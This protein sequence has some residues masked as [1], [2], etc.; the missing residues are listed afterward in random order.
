MEFWKQKRKSISKISF[1]FVFLFLITTPFFSKSGNKGLVK[2]SHSL[3]M[4][5]VLGLYSESDLSCSN[6]NKNQLQPLFDKFN[7]YID[8]L[9]IEIPDS[10]A[11]E[12]FYEK[13]RQNFAFKFKQEHTHR[14]MYHWGFD[15]D[16][17]LTAEGIPTD[18]QIPNELRNTFIYWNGDEAVSDWYRFLKFLRVEQEKRNDSLIQAVQSSLGLRSYSDARDIAA[19]IYY[20]HILGDHIE[21][22]GEHSADA[23]LELDKIKYNLENH[24]SSLCSSGKCRWFYNDYKSAIGKISSSD[25]RKYAENVINQLSIYIPKILQYRFSNEFASKNLKFIYIED[26]QKAS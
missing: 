15:F 2:D 13:I 6:Y 7:N 11:T 1:L 22:S 25:N 24:I 17:D 18:N 23:I 4:I 10:G 5:L 26:L 19:I 14:A 20:T 9:N 12:N 8:T 3:D 16:V 21:H